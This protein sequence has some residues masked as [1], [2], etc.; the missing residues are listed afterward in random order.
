MTITPAMLRAAA[1]GRNILDA[2]PQGIERSERDGQQALVAST[3]MPK[4][5]SP[6]RALFEAVGFKFGAD[7][8]DIFVSASLPDGWKRAATDHAMHSDIIDEQGRTRVGVFYKAAFYDR[9]ASA[10]L[11]R[12]YEVS[13]IFGSDKSSGLKDGERAYGVTDAGKEIFRTEAFGDQDWDADKKQSAAARDW[14][15][16][17]FPNANN[18]T[19]YW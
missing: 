5:M 9:R 16:L 17:N 7:V 10:H 3:N 18:P 12:R 1:E 6:D 13:Y 15:D 19:L 2:T 4:E 11:R 14:L 8:D